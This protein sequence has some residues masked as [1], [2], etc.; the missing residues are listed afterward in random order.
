MLANYA[1]VMLPLLVMAQPAHAQ[2]AETLRGYSLDVEIKA[3]HVFGSGESINART[4]KVYISEK[5]RLFDFSGASGT[6]A[7]TGHTRRGAGGAQIVEW[8]QVW[9]HGPIGQRWTTS[10]ATL[11]RERIYP[12][13]RQFINIRISRDRGS[14][15]ASTNLRSSRDDR[16]FFFYGIPNGK[17]IPVIDY[18]QISQRCTIMRGNI[19]T[20]VD[21]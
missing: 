2:L 21:I 7:R 13:G 4:I 18:R 1:I 14:C 8:G 10:G 6:D 5:G 16:Q 12:W 17:I 3:R 9:S 11:I 19:F 15:T 20:S